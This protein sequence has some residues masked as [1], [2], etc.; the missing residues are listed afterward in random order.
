MRRARLIGTVAMG[1]VV[2]VA[3]PFLGWAM[4]AVFAVVAAN[5]LT[6]DW[7]SARSSYPERSVA[8]SML[9]TETGIAVGV[10]L[11]GG[12]ASPL[13]PWLAA[14]IAMSAARFR[15]AVVTV[16]LGIGYAL[17]VAAAVV[18]DPA[19]ALSDPWLLAATLALEL[20]VVA[21]AMGLEDAELQHRSEAVLDPL[22][23]LLNRGS[24]MAR[25][26][27]V[28]EQARRG[29]ASVA[30]IAL[31][32][33]GF[34]RVN[35]EHGHATGDAVLRD[36][37]YAMR[38]ALRSFDLFYR[39]GGEEFVVVMPGM[40]LDRALLVAE[41]L[42]LAVQMA[43][44]AGLALTVSAGVASARGEELTFEGLFEAA[45]EALYDAKRRGRNRVSSAGNVRILVLT[46]ERREAGEAALV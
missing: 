22:T 26:P 32:I 8:L 13:L 39:Y 17:T 29:D 4:L 36:L 21:I 2:V 15:P 42:R 23:E 5:V 14:P 27:E 38:R 33:D 44:P 31:D 1:A 11:T 16:G 30:M 25:F 34:K 41:R 12:A 6:L 45:D 46:P 18:P 24:L 9:F 20:S 35:D 43:R 3:A 19:A 40:E 37:A 28:R 10:A 7:R